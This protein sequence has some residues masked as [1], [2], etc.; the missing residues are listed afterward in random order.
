MPP[1]QCVEQRT[2][3][4]GALRL[5]PQTGSFAEASIPAGAIG[6]VGP[7]YKVAAVLPVPTNVLWRQKPLPL[8]PHIRWVFFNNL[9]QRAGGVNKLPGNAQFFLQVLYCKQ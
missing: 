8:E 6:S 4:P 7:S 9:L 5:K 2:A 3:R 1:Q